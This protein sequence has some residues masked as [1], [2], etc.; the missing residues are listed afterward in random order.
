MQG[1]RD[2]SRYPLACHTHQ[3][4]EIQKRR[5]QFSPGSP[6]AAPALTSAAI[7][8]RLVARIR[9]NR[10]H[11]DRIARPAHR[12]LNGDAQGNAIL[13]FRIRLRGYVLRQRFCALI[14]TGGR[15][16]GKQT[17][18][19][20][21]Q[22]KSCDP[23]FH[24]DFPFLRLTTKPARR[25]L[26]RFSPLFYNDFSRGSIGLADGY[27]IAIMKNRIQVLDR[28]QQSRILQ[29]RGN[30]LFVQCFADATSFSLLM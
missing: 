3:Y 2:R 15:A 10:F 18:Q 19:H 14:P 9:H 12:V 20:A 25:C 26:C 4:Q 5:S 13:C 29:G 30:V 21:Q 1:C 28:P 8:N 16:G 27:E 6:D 11:L 22:Q 7:F 23:T 17:G 24:S